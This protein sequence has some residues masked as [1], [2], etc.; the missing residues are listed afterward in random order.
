MPIFMD[1]HDIPKE[2]TAAHVAQMHQEDLKVEHLYQC[3]GI[4]YWCDDKKHHAFCLIEAPNREAI[5]QMHNHAHGDFP[6]K[7]IEVDE[8]LVET[9]LGRIGDPEKI[10]N[11][12][13]NIIKESAY[14]SI[15]VIE[16]SSYIDRVEADQLSIF[17]QKFHSNITNTLNRFDGAVVKKNDCSYIVSFKSVSNA[18]LSAL[19]IQADIKYITLKFDKPTRRLNIGIASGTPVTDKENIFEEVVNLTTRMSEVVAGEIVISSE[20]NYLFDTEK[21]PIN[22]DKNKLRILDPVEEKFLTQLIDYIESVWK[23]PNIRVEDLCRVMGYSKS[24]LNR[25]LKS[26]TNK[27]PNN[28]IKDFKLDKS[29]DLFQRRK[30][31]ISQVAFEVG[32][33]SPAYFTKCFHEKFGILPSTYT[34]Q[35]IN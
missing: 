14:R 31:N 6:H 3:R 13:L 1:R 10:G 11:T 25:K 34:H 30:G 29:L 21:G 15:M 28:F 27:T 18:V 35:H 32:F 22:I 8:K 26:L 24:Q 16:T 12:E 5:Q 33:N 20:V 17:T 4:T 2:I 19:K 23:K 9:F 7:I